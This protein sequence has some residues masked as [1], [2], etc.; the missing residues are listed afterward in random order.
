[1]QMAKRDTH[2]RYIN[3][4]I[5]KKRFT[6]EKSGETQILLGRRKIIKKH[7]HAHRHT[8]TDTQES[9]EKKKDIRD[10]PHMGNHTKRKRNEKRK[11]TKIIRRVG[12]KMKKIM[13]KN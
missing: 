10:H 5:K 13:K 2:H 8:D 4:K 7:T 6:N 9:L 12:R 1:M 3:M 11:Q